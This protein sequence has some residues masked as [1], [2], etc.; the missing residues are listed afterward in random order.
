MLFRRSDQDERAVVITGMQVQLDGRDHG[1]PVTSDS[2]V[3]PSTSSWSDYVV[4]R[5]G[6]T[7][8]WL[9]TENLTSGAH[10]VKLIK[11][12]SYRKGQRTIEGRVVSDV[13]TFRIVDSAKNELIAQAG[14][15]LQNQVRKALEFSETTLNWQPREQIT[16]SDR[17]EAWGPQNWVF[18][19]GNGTGVH[20]PV[21]RITEALPVD[22]CFDV[23]LTIRST[24]ERLRAEPMVVLQGE[25]RQGWIDLDPTD[26]RLSA[27]ADSDG[28]LEVELK[29]TPSR[30]AALSNPGVRRYYPGSITTKPMRLKIWKAQDGP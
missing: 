14:D 22:L 21:W 1:E 15:E 24:G 26:E 27:A 18:H 8:A 23:E 25:S 2:R 3:R 20:A 7:R 19:D 6:R 29:L 30:E 10:A 12:F 17:Q 28:F 4:P 11:T 9:S 13:K 16:E 5:S